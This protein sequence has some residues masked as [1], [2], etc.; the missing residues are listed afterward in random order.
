ME[1]PSNWGRWSAEDEIGALNLIT[2]DHV[3]A[4]T[5]LVAA[6]RVL[7]LGRVIRHD[8][9]RVA[10]RTGPTHVLTVDGGDYAVGARPPG[11][12][13]TADDFIA[14]PLAT[15]THIDALAHVWG[16]D[17]L[18]NGHDPNLVRSRGAKVCGIDKVPGIVT[19]A[20]LADIC[21]LH[22]VDTLPPSHV[23]SV[24]ELEAA[25][26]GRGVV[27]EPG[28]ALLI[29]TG[30]LS[31]ANVATLG[32]QGL[33]AEEPGVGREAVG[34]IADHDIAVVGADTLGVEVLPAEQGLPG[35]PLHL[36]LITRLGVH[37]IEVLDFEE[38]A[39]A[40]HARFLFVVAP[41]RIKGAVN[42]PVNPLAIL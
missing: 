6:G 31:D 10:D 5:A 15:G 34:W 23:I 8:I 28:D 11:G 1:I 16:A 26:V 25:T 27:P 36:E 38:L 12:V 4:A 42:S 35:A 7:P 19:G 41:L 37:L 39:R 3:A 2:G 20:V 22:G 18:Y 14:M 21:G 13:R 33:E 9:V 29:R 30:W 40:R 24:A 32:G 17:G